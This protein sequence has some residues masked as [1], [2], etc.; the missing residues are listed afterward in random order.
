MVVSIS[1]GHMGDSSIA[2]ISGFAL[3]GVLP[4]IVG[5]SKHVYIPAPSNYPLRDPN[6]HLI[7]TR[8]P[9]IEVHCG[10]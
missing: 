6:Y 7:E 2:S 8:T 9:L 3:A 5:H 10:V 1:E 4:S